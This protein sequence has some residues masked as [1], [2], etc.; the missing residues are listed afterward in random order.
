MSVNVE[1]VYLQQDFLLSSFIIGVETKRDE[2]TLQEYDHRVDLDLE[3]TV[4][5]RS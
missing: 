3:L 1:A 2:N 5:H 4:Y